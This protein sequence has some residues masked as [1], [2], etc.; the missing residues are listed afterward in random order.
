MNPMRSLSLTHKIIFALILAA[1]ILRLP[2]IFERYINPDEFEHLHAIRSV[3]CGML[4]YRDFFEHHTPLL[5]FL[6]S[7][8]YSFSGDNIST[9]FIFRLLM[10]VFAAGIIYL[11]YAL[12]RFLYNS[13]VALYSIFFLSYETIFLDRTIEVRPDAPAVFFCL[14]AIILLIKAIGSGSSGARLKK[15]SFLS[16]MMLSMAFLFTQKTLFIAAGIFLSS[17]WALKKRFSALI[18]FG[19]GL[20][21]PMG[22][23]ALYFFLNGSLDDFIYRNFLMNIAWK[24]LVPPERF[25]DIFLTKD[26]FFSL[27]G[28]AGLVM[29]TLKLLNGKER[30]YENLV[31]LLSVYCV[32]LGIF[33]IPVPYTQYFL[34]FIP[35]ISIYCGVSLYG[36]T[37][38]FHARVRDSLVLA[39]LL[40]AGA[41]PIVHAFG[42]FTASKY[43]NKGQLK[44]IDFILKNTNADDSV[45][46]CWR[47]T[48]ALR[49]HAYY[50][51]F[52]HGEICRML[53]DRE[54][55]SDVI[56]A[57]RDR[58]PK[59]VIYDDHMNSLSPE[60]LDYITKNYSPTEF[61]YILI[62]KK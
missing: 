48:G 14:C 3:S 10:L 30:F 15:Y 23:T 50:Y 54:L 46:G 38:R 26:I 55:S 2:I 33:I 5:Y 56:E 61:R 25:L 29:A 43:S 34:F 13:T 60:V 1:F 47:G 49:D 42:Q 28:L 51:Y 9:I 57:L 40:C 18:W 8:I 35:L 52:L 20:V 12:S 32:I 21:I 27:L 24:R 44:E 41:M 22:I 36:L 16:G 37:K 45:F 62:L 53:T 11:T 6:F 31:P 58:R 39:L 59:F 17:L 4:P 19:V 7:P